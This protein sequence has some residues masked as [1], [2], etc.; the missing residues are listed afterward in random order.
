M[1]LESRVKFLVRLVVGGLLAGNQNSHIIT[2]ESRVKPH[3]AWN[4]Y[5]ETQHPCVTSYRAIRVVQY[6]DNV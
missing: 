3:F 4:N 1:G 2:L 5:A 6:S